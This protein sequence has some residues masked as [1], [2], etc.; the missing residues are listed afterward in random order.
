MKGMFTVEHFRAAILVKLVRMLSA[1]IPGISTGQ[2]QVQVG[3]PTETKI[4]ILMCQAL[5]C[6][7]TF[8]V[9]SCRENYEQLSKRMISQL[10][11]T[12]IAVLYPMGYIESRS[13]K[14]P[15][16]PLVDSDPLFTDDEDSGSGHRRVTEKEFHDS[17][18]R[19]ASKL[20]ETFMKE[21]NP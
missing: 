9:S 6:H 12:A 8:S 10:Q 1:F 17:V 2:F 21:V 5:Y 3:W 18:L 13:G 19:L 11:A 14:C 20:A 4:N 16:P 7:D 15:Q